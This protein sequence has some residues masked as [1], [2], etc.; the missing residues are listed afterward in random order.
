[1]RPILAELANVRVCVCIDAGDGSGAV[2][3]TAAA[4]AAEG[5]DGSWRRSGRHA[6]VVGPVLVHLLLL[7]LLLT[8]EEL[9][10]LLAGPLGRS[11]L[12]VADARGSTVRNMAN[13][14]KKCTCATCS[15][16]HVLG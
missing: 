5:V 3:D 7:L 2:E 15:S 10:L 12:A 8:T 14:S 16:L 6:L 1:M 9:K 13:M 11:A 4:A